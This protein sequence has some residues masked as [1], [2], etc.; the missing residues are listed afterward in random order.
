M[1]EM[2]V[3]QHP[4]LGRVLETTD[5]VQDGA[6]RSTT[7]KAAMSHGPWTREDIAYALAV[8]GAVA[9]SILLLGLV[10]G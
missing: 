1:T 8:V 6:G 2:Q 10:Q 5:G 9:G 4:E 7:G 3:Q